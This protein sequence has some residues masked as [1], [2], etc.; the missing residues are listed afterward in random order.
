M[1]TETEVRKIAK[2]ARLKLTE[3]EVKKFAG[4]LGGILKHID[5][6]NE[7]NTDGVEPTAQVTGLSNV[8]QD[9]THVNT[10]EPEKLLACSELPKV[11]GQIRVN[12]SFS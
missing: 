7:V 12:S 8:M 9:D 4:Q 3:S 10:P 11:R 1:L 2:L 6:L 5:A